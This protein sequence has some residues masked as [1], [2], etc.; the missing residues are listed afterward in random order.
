MHSSLILLASGSKVRISHMRPV[1]E[2]KLASRSVEL[3]KRTLIMGVVNVTPD[4]FSDG[5]VHFDRD[6]A[7]EHAL[8]LLRDGADII[9]VGGESTRPGTRQA[10]GGGESR[11]PAKAATST[12]LAVTEQEELD[13]VIPVITSLK[14]KQPAWPAPQ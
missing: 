2:W 14:K 4:S 12:K 5:G 3:G 11:E 13:R 10:S 7:V 6:R 8:Q 9:D 1:F